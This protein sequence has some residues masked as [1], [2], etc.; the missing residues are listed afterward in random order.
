MTLA[1]QR[2]FV[3]HAMGQGVWQGWRGEE[4]VFSAFVLVYV[5]GVM[6]APSHRLG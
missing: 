6:D 2:A 1:E 3:T 4:S 5:L